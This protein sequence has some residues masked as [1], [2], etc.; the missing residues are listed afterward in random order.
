MSLGDE[1]GAATDALNQA[2]T[3][4]TQAASQG[5]DW[6]DASGV[7]EK[8]REE[9]DEI[10]EALDHH[11]TDH[12]R[13]ELGDVLF[14]AVNLARFLEADP[15]RELHEANRRF[16]DRFTKLTAETRRS[17]RE[18]SDCSIH[19]LDAIWDRLKQTQKTQPGMG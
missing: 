7:I 4:Q 10:Q 5:F 8:M 1:T 6:S 16:A 17:G 13:L 14:T 9:L 2:W 15:A 19:E 11:D 12:A 18:P 3:I